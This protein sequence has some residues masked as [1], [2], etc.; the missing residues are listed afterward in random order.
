MDNRDNDPRID[1]SA[2]GRKPISPEAL[3]RHA[4]MEAARRRQ[5]EAEDAA[6]ERDTAIIRTAE[7]LEGIDGNFYAERERKLDR[8]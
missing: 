5:L 7:A 3:A 8:D 1:V 2:K 6:Q 4:I